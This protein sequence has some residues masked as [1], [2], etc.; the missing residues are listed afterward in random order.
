MLEIDSSQDDSITEMDQNNSDQNT[1]RRASFESD[2]YPSNE[3]N[4]FIPLEASPTY[5]CDVCNLVF[6]NATTL[7]THKTR[8]HEAYKKDLQF[9]CEF[10]ELAYEKE[11]SLKVHM[12]R[13]HGKDATPEDKVERICEMCSLAFVGMARLKMHMQRRH[14]LAI[15]NFDHKCPYCGLTYDKQTSLVVHMQRKHTNKEQVRQIYNCPF[16]PKLFTVRQSLMTHVRRKHHVTYQNSLESSFEA[17]VNEYGDYMCSQCP[18]AFATAAMLKIHLQR[19]HDACND[20]FNLRC[21]YCQLSY[22]KVSSLKRHIKR[23]HDKTSY[24]VTC[25]KQFDTHE[26]YLA[27]EHHKQVH[28]CDDCG[29]LFNS[30]RSYST[31]YSKMHAPVTHQTIFCDRCPATFTL[32]KH[33][34]SHIRNVHSDFTY[35]CG[36]CG[37]QFRVK[38]S[39]RQHVMRKHPLAENKVERPCPHCERTFTNERE[40]CGHVDNDHTKDGIKTE[41]ADRD[42]DLKSIYQ[43]RKCPES[44]L[45]FDLLKSHN[46]FLHCKILDITTGAQ[47]RICSIILPVEMMSQHIKVT[48]EEGLKCNF[49]DFEATERVALTK[50]LLRHKDVTPFKC[51]DPNCSY[52]TYNIAVLKKHKLKH[53]NEVIKYQCSK[54]PFQSINKYTL[55]YHEKEHFL[56]KK[57]YSC[58]KCEYTTINQANLVQHRNKHMTEKKFKC[59]VCSFAT[60]YN[61]SLRF[62]II[63]KHRDLPITNS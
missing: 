13:K 41:E 8:T 33:L 49:C 21:T 4:N 50:H 47:C 7:R 63:K 28:E 15:E 29:M 34:K 19:T 18:L 26:Q 54:C 35:T 31:H 43:C 3:E 25:Q 46:N 32:K 2:M 42:I 6:S 10:C 56:G 62:H 40:L 22:D 58:D 38:D 45:T 12:K 51:D 24:C 9:K 39:L 30:Q 37:K 11:P 17:N 44:F 16:C 48:H 52:S 61:T 1:A 27:H 23:K 5:I 53:S 20:T 60:K 57:H 55:K 14:G 36:Q 59:D